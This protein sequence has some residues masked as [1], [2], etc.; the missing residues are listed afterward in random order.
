MKLGIENPKKIAVLLVLMALAAGLLMKT[1][2]SA[3]T[4][5]V[6]AAPAAETAK[7]RNPKGSLLNS[8]D[9]S[10]RF[11]LLK[12]SEDVVYKGTGRNIFKS[13]PEPPPIPKPVQQ[14]LIYG[15]PPPPPPPPINLKFYGFAS[16]PGEPKRVF[17]SE[18]GDIFIAKE[19]D[20]VD[21]RYKV[22]HIGPNSVE[23][24]DVLNNNTQ[25]I[26]LTEA[27]SGMGPS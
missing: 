15:P 20:I 6:A 27:P 25:T 4:A 16:G 2:F 7:D 21:R 18:N 10:I 14:P 23:I 26:P 5:E 11:D 13:E 17:L 1:I 3:P 24:T 12:V 19:G 8:L 22:G 9:P